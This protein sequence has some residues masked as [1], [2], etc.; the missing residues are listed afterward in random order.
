VALKHIVIHRIYC[1]ICG[2]HK[3]YDPSD[4]EVSL[5]NICPACGDNASRVWEKIDEDILKP[6]PRIKRGP[7]P[8][9]AS[10]KR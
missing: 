4:L 1:G 7:S 9:D 2:Y 3:D 10:I 8:Y 6:K 5:P